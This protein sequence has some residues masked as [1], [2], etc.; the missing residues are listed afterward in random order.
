MVWEAINEW[1]LFVVLVAWGHVMANEAATFAPFDRR[2]STSA[3]VF[4]IGGGTN[5]PPGES[6]SVLD[7]RRSLPEESAMPTFAMETGPG[8]TT[9]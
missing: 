9:L 6:V 8:L 1:G 3:A 7:R 2:I 5:S 4:R